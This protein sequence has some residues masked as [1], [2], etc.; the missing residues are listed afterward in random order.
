LAVAEVQTVRP[1]DAGA[2][3]ELG[4][5]RLRYFRRCENAAST[6]SKSTRC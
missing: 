4:G 6:L 3:V 2:V 1:P 5:E